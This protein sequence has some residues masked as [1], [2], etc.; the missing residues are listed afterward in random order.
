MMIAV[1]RVF[2]GV[3]ILLILCI[4]LT[5]ADDELKA[6]LEGNANAID[7]L[8]KAQ[9]LN[10]SENPAVARSGFVLLQELARGGNTAAMLAVANCYVEGRGVVVNPELAYTAFRI[11]A[12]NGSSIGVFETAVRLLDGNGVKPNHALGTELMKKAAEEGVADAVARLAEAALRQYQLNGSRSDELLKWSE[13]GAALGLPSCQ[14]CLGLCYEEGVGMAANSEIAFQLYSQAAVGGDVRGIVWLALCHVNG[15]G[16]PVNEMKA[17]QLLSEAASTSDPYACYKFALLLDEL[18]V[19][20]HE[21]DIAL[22]PLNYSARPGSDGLSS[23]YEKEVV[24]QLKRAADLLHPA[25][26]VSLAAKYAYGEGCEVNQAAAFELASNAARMG[27]ADS[28]CLLG[29]LYEN[30]IGTRSD[31]R[32]A[33]LYYEK[34]ARRGLPLAQYRYGLCLATGTGVQVDMQSCIRWMAASSSNGNLDAASFLED[35][36]ARQVNGVREWL[37]SLVYDPH[38]DTYLLERNDEF[39]REQAKDDEARNQRLGY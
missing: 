22:D 16:T 17:L 36:N 3:G 18:V 28:L 10:M 9:Q 24:L 7:R 25:A 35:L 11:A 5:N 21:Q 30:G 13:R 15:I 33:A 14:R 34:A 31:V 26:M 39:N 6:Q 23:E 4:Q 8:I 32:K 12:D 19:K 2:G 37:E 29:E 38:I 20:K 1:N 27:I